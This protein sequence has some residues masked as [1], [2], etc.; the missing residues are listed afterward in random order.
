MRLHLDFTQGKIKKNL[1]FTSDW[2]LFHHNVLG[3]DKRPF[4]NV[5]EMH[6]TIENNW[7]NLI[8]KDDV[9]IYLGDLTF[10]RR[11]DQASVKQMMNRLNGDIHFV[12]GN[13]DKWED[14]AA[15]T[16]FKSQQD[17]LEIRLNYFDNEKIKHEVTFLCMH[18]PI[19]SWNKKHRGAYMVHGHSHMINSDDDFH[20]TNRL[21]DVGCNGYNYTPVSFEEI[22]EIKKD[23]DYM[24]SSNHHKVL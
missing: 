7:N 24:L 12:M 17:Y 3:F 5:D 8:T 10:A 1:Y 14:I 19:Y 23:I 11:E 16:K 20:K 2:H 6:L 13:H 15:I 9:V 22:I 4:D 18:Y 21:I